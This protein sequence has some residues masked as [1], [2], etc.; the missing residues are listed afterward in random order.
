[1]KNQNPQSEKIRV[2]IDPDLQ[3]LIPGYLENRGK[4]LLVFQQALEKGNFDAIAVLGHSMKGSG[5]GYG[6]NGLSS[7]GQAIENAAKN[8]DKESVRKSIINLTDF[9]KKLEIVYD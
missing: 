3:D 9:L 1:M 4:D 6:L 8:R 2:H 5:G 7:I